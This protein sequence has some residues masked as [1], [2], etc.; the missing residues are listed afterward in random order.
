MRHYNFM[1]SH[2]VTYGCISYVPSKMS[3]RTNSKD[4]AT[5]C[6]LLNNLFVE[7][8]SETGHSTSKFR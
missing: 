4:T 5:S 8:N 2:N 3:I 6:I 1:Q 7:I